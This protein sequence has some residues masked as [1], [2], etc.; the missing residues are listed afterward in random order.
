LVVE[1]KRG[2]SKTIIYGGLPGPRKERGEADRYI[3]EW[4]RML[5]A[6]S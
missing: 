1:L 5:A 2:Y 6:K 4:K 3:E